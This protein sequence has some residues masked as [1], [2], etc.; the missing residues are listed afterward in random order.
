MRSDRALPTS[1]GMLV[2][3]FQQPDLVN[4][5]EVLPMLFGARVQQ[6][7]VPGRSGERACMQE[8]GDVQNQEPFDPEKG[9]RSQRWT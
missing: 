7:S 4:R 3:V 1:T 8:L 6:D 9:Q 5:S 2:R